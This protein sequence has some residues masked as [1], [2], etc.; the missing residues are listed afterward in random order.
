MATTADMKRKAEKI[1]AIIARL[2]EI[3]ESR[4]ML[5]PML[6]EPKL[7]LIILALG[8]GETVLRGTA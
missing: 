5:I 2:A 6:D 4:E 7:H 1:E 3:H 8:I